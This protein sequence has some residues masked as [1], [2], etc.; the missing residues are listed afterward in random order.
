[1]IKNI[2]LKIISS[3]L[4]SSLFLQTS[5]G[6]LIHSE[7]RHKPHSGNL[8]FA[9]VGLDA[10]GLLFFIIPGVIAFAVDFTTH[11]IYLPNGSNNFSSADNSK[12]LAVKF[13]GELTRE[14]IE[15][16]VKENTGKNVKIDDK[17][18]VLGD[19]KQKLALLN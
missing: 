8:D 3:L 6:Y 9:I 14:K 16:L 2:K 4:V 17:T 5:C 11:T 19:E 10:I 18:L 15:K 7:R 13:D 1:M 12:N